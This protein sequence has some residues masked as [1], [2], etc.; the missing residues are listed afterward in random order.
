MTADK[1]KVVQRGI[2]GS[3]LTHPE[4]DG[5]FQ[6]LVN[7]IDDVAAIPNTF[8]TI[9][10]LE[11]VETAL[12]SKTEQTDIDQS[13]DAL[14]TNL[15]ATDGAT[16]VG[17]GAGTV[18]AALDA[19]TDVTDSLTSDTGSD[20]VKI[21][22]RTIT[23]RFDDALNVLDFVQKPYTDTSKHQAGIVAAIAAAKLQN[24]ELYWPMLLTSTEALADLHTVRHRGPGGIVAGSDTF[25]VDPTPTQS[26]KLYMAP[27]GTGDGITSARPLNGFTGTI[28][29]LQQYAPLCTRWDVVGSAG[30]YIET[31]VIPDWIAIGRSYLAFTFPAPVGDRAEPATYPAI[32]SGS[33]LTA[34]QGF[35]SG[36]GNRISISNLAVNNWYDSALTNVNQVRRGL[37]VS[38]GSFVYLVNCAM[39]NN[40][41]ANVSA[42]PGGTAVVTGGVYDGARY[43]FDNTGGR[44]SF[45]AT[46]TTYSVVRNAL[47]YGL[48][49]KHD[50]STVM[51]Y[52]EFRN[53]GNIAAAVSYGAAIFAYKSNASVDTRG[54]KFYANNICW[55]VRGGF[56]ADNPGIPDVYGTG[57]DANARRYLCRGGGR[58]DIDTYETNSVND[59][60][61][62]FGGGS[63]TSATDVLLLDAIATTREGY[64]ANTDQCLKM[65]L[66]CRAQTGD[67]LIT[68]LLRHAGGTVSLGTYRIT[69][70]KYGE[71]RLVIR[72]TSGQ[73]T[74]QV[75][76]ACTDAIQNL[77]AAVGQIISSTVDLKTVSLSVEVNGRAEGGGTASLMTCIVEKSG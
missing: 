16:R 47:E 63:T 11:V 37:S 48:Y 76:F 56:V 30:T 5:N 44:L 23:E 4:L 26:N 1:T 27:S 10:S 21:R 39:T 6:E 45:S 34:L 18:A 24:K 70:G 28:G 74:L 71:I 46:T 43:G 64:L 67:A 19:V 32:L 41:L 50:S 14:E 53:C 68:P 51:D 61:K 69:A 17:H 20:V 77:G 35:L 29:V 9:A 36:L 65:Q 33:G 57:A 72:P 66:F 62:R 54:V 55:N 3:K 22:G 25:Y 42:L 40:G 60:T 38:S 59:I 58:D 52:T 15:S 8:A 13:I 7:V 49:Q 75:N 31:V 73:T 2:K 12:Q